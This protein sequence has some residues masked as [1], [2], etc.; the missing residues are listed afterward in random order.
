PG[1][2]AST[3]YRHRGGPDSLTQRGRGAF[4]YIVLAANT[5][6]QRGHKFVRRLDVW[7]W[8]CEHLIDCIDDR[9]HYAHHGDAYLRQAGNI[10]RASGV[11]YDA[12][13]PDRDDDTDPNDAGTGTARCRR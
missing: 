4:L 1:Y 9:R 7:R 10:Y 3:R 5:A 6:W 2:H 8:Q 11:H 12:A 13:G